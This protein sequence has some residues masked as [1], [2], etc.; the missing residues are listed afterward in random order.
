MWRSLAAGAD[1]PFAVTAMLTLAATS[2]RARAQ[3]C[4]SS[5]TLHAARLNILRLGEDGGL[6]NR[7]TAYPQLWIIR[8]VPSS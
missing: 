3:A 4:S 8:S 5:G 6:V 2:R 1:V 7:V